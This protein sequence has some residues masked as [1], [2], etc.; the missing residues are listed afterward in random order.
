[1]TSTRLPRSLDELG[2]LRAARW[3]RESTSGQFDRYG[4]DAQRE[5]EARSIARLGLVDTG[6]EYSAAQSGS[7]VHSGPAMRAMLADAATGAFDVLVVG[8]VARWQRNLRQTLNLLEEDLHPAGVAVW[9]AD[10]ELLSSNDRH[11]D[12]L[13]DE[14][15]GAESWLRKHR[16]RVAEGYAAKRA[17]K[18]D[19]GGHAPFGF[20]R[21]EAKLLEA[22]PELAGIVRGIFERAAARATDREIAAAVN[23][24]LYT[25][26]G[27]VTSPLY[28][29]RLRTGERAHWPPLV[30]PA[31]W[32]EVQ[33]V[34]ARRRTRDGRPGRRRPYALTMLH[35]AACGR[36]LIG[37]TG[38]MRHP[39]PCPEFVAVRRE[40]RARARGQRRGM[41]GHSYRAEAYEAIV[42]DVLAD[43][44]LGADV[45]AATVALTRDPEPDRLAL[46][47]VGR[48]RDAAMA[49]YRRDRDA[50]ELE[51]TMAALDE[52]E[53]DARAV[54]HPATLTAAEAV[55]YLRDLPRW[56][57]DAPASRRGLAEAL[58][59]RIEVLGL[60][61]MRLVPTPAAIAA[62]LADAFASGSAGYGRGE[63]ARAR[64]TRH[65]RG[66]TVSIDGRRDPLRLANPART[67]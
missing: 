1:M 47:R 26:R 27:V 9:F 17:T 50:R 15:K 42:R 52:Q 55:A 16:R 67:A 20:R 43:V 49:R 64:A 48:E 39:D 5:L 29:G 24:S 53:A 31:L 13:V 12:Q 14:A 56:W 7:T 4:P 28:V 32:E 3:I 63:R 51:S 23:L 36:H 18:R 57:N 65:I 2:G 41:P 25:V 30:E 66:C 59:D 46:A 35:C 58:F 11:W 62:G 44:S 6:L 38:R 61:R 21:N 8:Y 37:D 40:P 45:V 19:P 10:E 34:R 60:R 54:K 22:D 33:A